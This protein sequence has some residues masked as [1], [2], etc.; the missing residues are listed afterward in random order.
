MNTQRT[1]VPSTRT[2]A[3]CTGTLGTRTKTGARGGDADDARR[4][5][6]CEP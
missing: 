1:G 3:Q 2:G 4:R 6:A 5:P